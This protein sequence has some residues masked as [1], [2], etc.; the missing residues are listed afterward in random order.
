MRVCSTEY[1]YHYLLNAQMGK[2]EQILEN[3]LR[4]LSDF[5][6]TK[7]WQEIEANMPGFYRN[8][9]QNIAEPIL[10]KPYRNSGIFLTPIDFYPLGDTLPRQRFRIAVDKI[11]PS[12]ACLTYVINDQRVVLPFTAENLEQVAIEWTD[13]QVQ[14][15]FGIDP[16]RLFFYV[17]QIVTYQGYISVDVA[18]LEQPSKT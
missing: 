13:E 7:Q 1:L 14:R 6:E 15:W 5:P 12:W 3:G 17:P 2:P 4:P 8:L 16:H 9:Y 10:K 11:D 18:D